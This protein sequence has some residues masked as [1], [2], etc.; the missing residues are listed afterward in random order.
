[1]TEN[2]R[3][4]RALAPG[5]GGLNIPILLNEAQ[6]ASSSGHVRYANMLWDICKE[7][8][9]SGLQELVHGIKI[10]MTVSEVGGIYR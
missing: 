6:K 4:Q 7:D 9:Q 1:M 8:P 3:S 10:F 2:E 5:G